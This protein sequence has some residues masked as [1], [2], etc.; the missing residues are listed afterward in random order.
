LKP[1]L[2]IIDV[3]IDFLDLGRKPTVSLIHAIRSLA[4]SFREAG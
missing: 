3:L 1:A 2:L 4:V